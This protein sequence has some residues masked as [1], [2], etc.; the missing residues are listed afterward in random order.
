MRGP[1]L[2]NGKPIPWTTHPFLEYID[3]L[4]LSTMTMAE[5]GAGH[6]TVYF[7]EKVSHLVSYECDSSL[8]LY[9]RDKYCYS[10]EIIN[11]D[12]R[13][14]G[15]QSDFK[16]DII[17]ID[18]LDR[19]ELLR[20]LLDCVRTGAIQRPKLVIIDNPNFVDQNLLTELGRNGYIRVDFFG[21]VSDLFYESVTSLFIARDVEDYIFDSMST[22]EYRT[23]F[24]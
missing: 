16:K 8:I 22:Y 14:G 7:K 4:D 15:Q 20:V 13:Y 5:F 11:V 2:E 9:L 12:Q 1:V 24:E 6:S 21:M 19:D 18:G 10:G 3:K 23:L 17:F